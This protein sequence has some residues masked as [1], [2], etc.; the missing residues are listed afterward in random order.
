MKRRLSALAW[1]LATAPAWAQTPSEASIDEVLQLTKA[2]ALL[3]GV[4]ANLDTTLQQV[5]AQ[6]VQ[7]RTLTPRQKRALDALPA[8]MSKVVRE[9]L[10]WS[11]LKPLYVRVYRQSFTQ[12]EIDGLIAFY[13]SP[14][15]IALVDKMPVVMQ[16]TLSELQTRIPPLVEKMQSAAERALAEADARS[17]APM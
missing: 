4:Y 6:S 16:Q 8:E 13:K 5:L 2:E 10:A 1:L 12:P 7:G 9:E 15:G 3:A 11:N 17:G 14:A